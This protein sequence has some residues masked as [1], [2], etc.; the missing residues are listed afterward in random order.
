MSSQNFI[1]VVAFAALVVAALYAAGPD[2]VMTGLVVGRELSFDTTSASVITDM[3]S[4][5]I[6]TSDANIF[7]GIPKL[8]S[9]SSSS[10]E[11]LGC[12]SPSIATSGK[13]LFVVSQPQQSDFYYLGYN[14]H[15]TQNNDQCTAVFP[16]TTFYKEGSGYRSAGFAI[17]PAPTTYTLQN[18]ADWLKSKSTTSAAPLTAPPPGGTPPVLAPPISDRVIAPPAGSSPI[19]GG[20]ASGQ[21]GAS[22][23]T[24]SVEG[25]TLYNLNKFHVNPESPTGADS[26]ASALFSGELKEKSLVASNGVTITSKSSADASTVFE[27]KSGTLTVSTEC[28]DNPTNPKCQVAPAVLKYLYDESGELKLPDPKCTLD[29]KE[30]TDSKIVVWC[31]DKK[32]AT[33]SPGPAGHSVPGTPEAPTTPGKVPPKEYTAGPTSGCIGLKAQIVEGVFEGVANTD[34]VKFHWTSPTF[35]GSDLDVPTRVTFTLTPLE[36]KVTAPK[37]GST[38]KPTEEWVQKPGA[39]VTHICYGAKEVADL[40]TKHFTPKNKDFKP[41]PCDYDF[42]ISKLKPAAG[43]S[44]TPPVENPQPPKV[45][46]SQLGIVEELGKDKTYLRFSADKVIQNKQGSAFRLK[47]GDRVRV[48]IFVRHLYSDEYKQKHQDGSVK[49]PQDGYCGTWET[50]GIS[51]EYTIK[52]GVLVKPKPPAPAKPAVVPQR[53]AVPTGGGGRLTGGGVPPASGDAIVT[54]Q[55]PSIGCNSGEVCLTSSDVNK[56]LCVG[57]TGSHCGP[58]G[59]NFCCA[60]KRK[61]VAPAPAPKPVVMHTC[62]CLAWPITKP[63]YST[64]VSDCSQCKNFCTGR[65]V[66]W[67]PSCS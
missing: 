54:R 35:M 21:V 51:A 55:T 53:V 50:G 58:N 7:N 1:A 9:G 22:T 24:A 17:Q 8:K 45:L 36:K 13:S 40:E 63:V 2:A 41:Q 4:K 62:N 66:G 46:L 43:T 52:S 39:M 20:S 42:S 29:A 3:D 31:G 56:N 59:A 38:A 34:A 14:S 48:K 11:P 44:A 67:Q 37:K 19:A 6:L 10:W 60:S 30:Q 64:T 33:V 26:W 23:S 47:E 49:P 16:L 28:T 27:I 15:V 32:P 5:I 18:F 25:A 57:Y 65:V 12:L 61:I